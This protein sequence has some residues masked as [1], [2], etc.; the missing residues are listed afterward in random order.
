MSSYVTTVISGASIILLNVFSSQAHKKHQFE[1]NLDAFKGLVSL[2][3]R[4]LSLLE[5][6]FSFNGVIDIN[7]VLWIAKKAIHISLLWVRNGT[8]W[9][10]KSLEFS[11]I[12]AFA[13]SFETIYGQIE[14]KACTRQT[15]DFAG[16]IERK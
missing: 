7:Q 2:W 15:I 4:F 12:L 16:K 6:N 10:N 5:F 11:G 1:A 13:F 3:I 8:K 9:I 14:D